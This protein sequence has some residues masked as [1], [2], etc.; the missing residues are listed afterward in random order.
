MTIYAKTCCN[1]G[2]SGDLW[3]DCCKFCTDRLVSEMDKVPSQSY[4]FSI[5]SPDVI[6]ET[7]GRPISALL[8]RSTHSG[9]VQST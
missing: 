5:G 4:E 6:Q 1:Q 3:D 8:N 9:P 2:Y 7:N